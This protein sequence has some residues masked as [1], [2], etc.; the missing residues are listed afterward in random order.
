M[1][2]KEFLKSHPL[3]NCYSIDKALGLPVGTVRMNRPIPERHIGVIAGLLS[4][5]G[6]DSGAVKEKP[7]EVIK[8]AVVSKYSIHKHRDGYMI[9]VESIEKRWDG[10]IGPVLRDVKDI[11]DNTP[12]ILG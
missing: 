10:K 1:D 11:Q 12:V 2:I 3:I 9:K 8:Q 5:Y 7:A 6:Y 4:A